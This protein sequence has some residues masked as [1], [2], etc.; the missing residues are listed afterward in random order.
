M[1]RHLTSTALG[2]LIGT[3]AGLSGAI[4]IGVIAL[5]CGSGLRSRRWQQKRA[6]EC[7]AGPRGRKRS[8]PGT[9][10][11]HAGKNRSPL[12][13]IDHSSWCRRL[14]ELLEDRAVPSLTVGSENCARACV[15][16]LM[17]SSRKTRARY[18]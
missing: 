11:C 18:R 10:E 12:D 15:H 2:A 6:C 8:R 9:I 1:P 16:R 7:P 3:L 13:E 14:L 17:F 5:G 4:M